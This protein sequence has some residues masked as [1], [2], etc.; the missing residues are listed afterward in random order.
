VDIGPVRFVTTKDGFRIAYSV[1]GVGPPL[2]VIPPGLTDLLAVWKVYPNWMTAL[3]RRF[4]VVV[5]DMRGRGL[6]S[7]GLTDSFSHLDYQL[8]VEAVIEDA[9]LSRITFFTI[10][11][12]GHVAV[13]YTVAHPEQVRALI[14]SDCPV[15]VSAYPRTVIEGL[16]KENWQYFVA[17]QIPSDLAPEDLHEWQQRLFRKGAYEDWLISSKENNRSSV[18]DELPLLRVPCLI[19]HSR[20]LRLFNPEE[21]IKFAAGIQRA[22]VVLVAGGPHHI[23][24][25]VESMPAVDAFMSDAGIRLAQVRDIIPERLGVGGEKDGLLPVQATLSIRQ[26]EVLQLI[27]D[28]KTTREIS[29]LLVLSE[30]TVERHIADLYNKIGARNRAE[31]TAYALRHLS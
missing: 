22:R 11:G 30:R 2:V 13:R 17:R 21:S 29:D 5:L 16:A 26:V 31:A 8:D 6:S 10:G 28:G 7:H 19:F 3:A 4:Q 20:D 9:Q 25:A 14:F 18:E 23:G 24:D 15:S 27:A 1:T 12:F